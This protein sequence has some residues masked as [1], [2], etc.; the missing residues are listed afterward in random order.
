LEVDARIIDNNFT[1]GQFTFN[2]TLKNGKK[3]LLTEQERIGDSY[4]EISPVK[5]FFLVKSDLKFGLINRDGKILVP[6]IYDEINSFLN[7]NYIVI[8]KD[9]KI[10]IMTNDL[11]MVVEPVNYSSLKQGF[12][13]DKNLVFINTSKIAFFSGHSNRIIKEITFES[14]EFDKY[15]SNSNFLRVKID[16]KWGLWSFDQKDFIL[17]PKYNHISISEASI[18]PRTYIVSNDKYTGVLNSN[19][20]ELIPFKYSKILIKHKLFGVYKGFEFIGYYD[21]NGNKYFDE[22]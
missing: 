11:K 13:F 5:D 6:T 21:L 12:Y 3:R 2:E 1:V 7:D 8:N 16:G 18:R 10:G 19:G 22:K 4:D 15:T 17:E 20:S 9:N 14:I